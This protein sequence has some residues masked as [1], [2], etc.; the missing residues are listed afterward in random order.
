MNNSQLLKAANEVF[1]N[2]NQQAKGVTV[3]L[4]RV[5]VGNPSPEQQT[6]APSQN[7]E[8]KKRLPLRRD[9]CAFCKD[10]PLEKRVP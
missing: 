10:Q 9:Q 1:E 2:R 7:K 5:A 8:T 4:L 6:A 3:S